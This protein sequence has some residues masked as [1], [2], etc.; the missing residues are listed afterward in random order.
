M[1]NS[2]IGFGSDRP[3]CLISQN[4]L[5][6]KSVIEE[7][8]GGSSR[9][10]FAIVQTVQPLTHVQVVKT[11]GRF[12]RFYGSRDNRY[13]LPGH[14]RHIKIRHEARGNSQQ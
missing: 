7:L 13:F 1:P 2:H 3:N 5:G 11:E 10:L 12:K 9:G 6:V 4:K 14:V 8:R